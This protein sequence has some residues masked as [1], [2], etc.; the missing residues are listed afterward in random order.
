MTD[1]A[2]AMDA[3]GVVTP[4]LGRQAQVDERHVDRG[5]YGPV[6][7]GGPGLG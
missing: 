6:G 4:D 2:Y 5:V 1:F 7:H 3:D